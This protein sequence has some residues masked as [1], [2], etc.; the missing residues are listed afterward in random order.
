MSDQSA[1]IRVEAHRVHDSWPRFHRQHMSDVN[2]ELRLKNQI[3][4][5][6]ERP[7]VVA[8]MRLAINAGCLDRAEPTPAGLERLR[9]DLTVA[10]V[11]RGEAEDAE[12]EEKYDEAFY[13]GGR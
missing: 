13:G 6:V 9:A 8:G 1:I 7:G 11:A 5:E 2:R 12:R 10:M 4:A 3:A